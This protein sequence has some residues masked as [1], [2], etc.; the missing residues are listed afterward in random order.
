MRGSTFLLSLLSATALPDHPEAGLED[1]RCP[2]MTGCDRAGGQ[3]VCDARHSCLGS[4]TYLDQETCM[5]ASKSG[6][7]PSP[8]QHKTHTRKIHKMGN[9]AVHWWK[10]IHNRCELKVTNA[11]YISWWWHTCS[12]LI[13]WLP[14]STRVV[15]LSVTHGLIWSV[16]LCVR[17]CVCL[18]I[19]LRGSTARAPGA[20]QGEVRG[21]LQ[22]SL[23]V[24]GV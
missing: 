4:F 20:T 19:T 14:S 7:T 13:K 16:C 23:H 3:C 21:T 22:T 24:L 9:N 18:L 2:L 8:S 17:A 6:E 11:T 5:K 10:L 15:P 12:G 1:E